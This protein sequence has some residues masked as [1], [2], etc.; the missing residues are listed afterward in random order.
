MTRRKGEITKADLRRLW[1]NVASMSRRTCMLIFEDLEA[2]TESTFEP[3]GE[4]GVVPDEHQ[5]A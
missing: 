5:G 3:P 1:D 4:S 2:L